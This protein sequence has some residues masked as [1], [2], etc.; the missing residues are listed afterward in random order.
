MRFEMGFSLLALIL[1]IQNTTAAENN[2]NALKVYAVRMVEGIQEKWAGAGIYLGQGLVITAGHVTG[3]YR[4]GVQIDGL[5]F[6]ANTVKRESKIDLALFAID[7]EK[8]TPD[9][10]SRNLSFCLSEAEADAPVS[11]ITPD[12]ISHSRI[13]SPLV[14][15]PTDRSKWGTMI[16]DTETGGKSG[17]GVFDSEKLCLLGILTAKI[18]NRIQFRDHIESK[19][20]GTFFVPASTIQF[21]LPSG[22][23]Y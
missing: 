23:R 10:R 13:A 18:S 15:P 21:F 8:L 6:P 7:S 11:V 3:A 9:L 12:G 5:T 17:S 20:I 2:D 19:D 22:Y 14:L 1:A 16:K 4:P